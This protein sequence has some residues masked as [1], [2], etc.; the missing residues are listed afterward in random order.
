MEMFGTIENNHRGW[1]IV[2]LTEVCDFQGGLSRLKMNG[3]KILC[4]DIFECFRLGIL[5]RRVSIEQSM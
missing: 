4:P 3:Y 1:R 5:H 2:P